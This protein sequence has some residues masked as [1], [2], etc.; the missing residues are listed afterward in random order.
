M[1]T[2]RARVSSAVMTHP[3]R[4]AQAQELC[5]R[6][7]LGGLAMDPEP[8]GP[9]SALRTALVAWS[10]IADGATHQLFI[11]DDFPAPDDI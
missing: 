9:P 11:Q 1:P 8:D 6:L 4:R 7:G 10:R 5:D 3:V 2:A